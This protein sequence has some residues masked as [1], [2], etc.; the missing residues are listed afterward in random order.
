MYVCTF[1]SFKGGVGRTMALVNVAA[2]LAKRKKRV[3]VVDFDIEAP[4]I[5]T[6]EEFSREQ[7]A[8]GIVDYVTDYL[9][10]GE[11]PL[12]QEY[13]TKCEQIAPDAGEIFLMGPGRQDTEYGTR[14]HQINWHDL[15]QRRAGFLLFEDLKAQWKEQIRPDYVLID[16][17]TGHT[18][19]GGICTRQL[20][21]AVAIMFSPNRQNLTGLRKIVQDIRTEKTRLGQKTIQIHF[22]MSNIPDI[23]DE[24]DVLA[25]MVDE[26]KFSLNIENISAT[27]HHYNSLNLIEQQ[28]FTLHREKTRLAKEYIE[29]TDVIVEKN[30]EDKDGAVRFL[31]RAIKLSRSRGRIKEDIS[32]TEAEVHIT[33][34]E[35]YHTTD[36]DIL[37]HLATY[38]SYRGDYTSAVNLL[39]RAIEHGSKIPE[40]FARRLVLRR[41]EDDT[42]GVLEDAKTILGLPDTGYIDLSLAAGTLGKLEPESLDILP[43][44]PAV[45]NLGV[46][47]K[48]IL[49]YR[50]NFSSEGMRACEVILRE[51][52]EKSKEEFDK[53]GGKIPLSLSLN[54]MKRFK[55][56][57]ALF[58]GEDK[59]PDDF[60][61]IQ[62]VYNFSIALW[63][64]KREIPEKHFERVLQLAGDN[65]GTPRSSNFNQ[66][67]AIAAWATG[68]HDD[69][70]T[71]L[72]KARRLTEDQRSAEFSTWRYLKI[73]SEEFL[74]DL[75]ELEKM[76]SGENV[77][78]R[79]F[80]DAAKLH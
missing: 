52:Q 23:D 6:F 80:G 28:L 50:L 18:D 76:L 19:I 32:N 33:K 66:C 38:K 36:P 61:T 68:R 24:Q 5:S 46:D 8:P 72:A 55:D 17:R 70:A 7:G 60:D 78:P 12:A 3:L 71:Y 37:F 57:I 63:G 75:D 59:S 10:N 44:S 25:K 20:P 48:I 26:F 14:L 74:R 15:Y 4:G 62:D 54:H 42:V 2:E 56:T 27:L 9:K 34:I 11:A 45:Q 53:C 30:A 41:L 29:F 43:A 47:D 35:D 64:H 65:A 79:I 51:A 73:E 77:R 49:G 67:L 39:D 58:G 40:A 16:S 22:T 21:H 69:S 31:K 1:Y 13:I